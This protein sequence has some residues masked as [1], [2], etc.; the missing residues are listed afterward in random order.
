MSSGGWTAA[1][2][3]E[4]LQEAAPSARRCIPRSSLSVVRS[5]RREAL[6]WE[7]N[8]E[9]RR[10]LIDCAETSLKRIDD[11]SQDIVIERTDR[12]GQ[13]YLPGCMRGCARSNDAARTTP[14]RFD[15]AP[16]R[17]GRLLD[18]PAR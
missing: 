3:H 16:V 1:E 13:K 4:A 8:V 14:L 15:P 17:Q 7:R 6:L 10:M 12:H 9:Q 11:L 5:W 18:E 2:I